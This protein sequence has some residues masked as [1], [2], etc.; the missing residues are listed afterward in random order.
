MKR[1]NLKH[2]LLLGISLV[3]LE[4]MSQ[5]TINVAGHTAKINGMTFEYSIGEMTLISTERNASL[6]VTQGLLQPFAASS[7][8][9]GSVSS[10]THLDVDNPIK[11]YPNPTSHLLFIES[12]EESIIDYAY[13]LYDATGKIVLSRQGQTT[14]GLNKV[15]LNLQSLASGNYY[16]MMQKQDANKGI[17]NYSYKIQKLN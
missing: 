10:D 13:N 12:F 9:D 15:E 3:S 5:Q 17:Q 14:V 4:G 6:L 1:T 7:S 16:L 11:V 8:S 2:L